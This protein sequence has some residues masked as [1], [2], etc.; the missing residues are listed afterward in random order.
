M[1]FERI[2]RV[3][4]PLLN[5]VLTHPFN[6]E[7]FDGTLCPTKFSYFLAQDALYLKS[8]AHTLRC[9]S[10]RLSEPAH[11]KAFREFADDTVAA[12][13]AMHR[14]F[15]FNSPPVM[16]FAIRSYIH[17]LNMHANYSPISVSIAS[18]LPCFVL[19]K[20]LGVDMAIVQIEDQHP[21]KEWV[22][23]YASPGFHKS[24]DLAIKILEEVSHGQTAKTEEK[25]KTV[26]LESVKYEIKFWEESYAYAPPKI[27]LRF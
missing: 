22:K 20:K 4:Q 26:F 12:E 25:M 24:T 9:I 2:N 16:S 14:K 21:F 10:N 23:T 19:Y 17:H 8:Y 3:A 11:K 5:T 13:Q 1:A 6:K 18:A 27:S 7:L 15:T